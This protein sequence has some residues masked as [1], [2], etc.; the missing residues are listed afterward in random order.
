WLSELL[1]WGNAVVLLAGLFTSSL[2]LFRYENGGYGP[3]V[4]QLALFYAFVFLA[5]T[6][7]VIQG[8][9][10]WKKQRMTLKKT[11]M[12]GGFAITF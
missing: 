9:K 8:S 2:I 3:Y 1:V 10:A 4:N 12:I 5:S 6:V 7:L 11:M